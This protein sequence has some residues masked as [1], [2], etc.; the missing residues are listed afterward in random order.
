MGKRK[1][2][3]RWPKDDAAVNGEDVQ[4]AEGQREPRQKIIGAESIQ[5]K[6]NVDQEV[7]N[8]ADSTVAI[9]EVSTA[10]EEPAATDKPDPQREPKPKQETSKE[11]IITPTA[12]SVIRASKLFKASVFTA[13][14]ILAA[15]VGVM[16][17]SSQANKEQTISTV[18]KNSVEYQTLKAA[19]EDRFAE[20]SQYYI[21]GTI[22]NTYQ[23]NTVVAEDGSAYVHGFIAVQE[24]GSEEV[25]P[26]EVLSDY[27]SADGKYYITKIDEKGANTGW[28]D[29]SVLTQN[30]DYIKSMYIQKY[31]ENATSVRRFAQVNLDKNL[32]GVDVYEVGVPGDLFTEALNLM[33]NAQYTYLYEE[34]IKRGDSEFKDMATSARREIRTT[35]QM[36]DGTIELGV[37]DGKLYYFGINTGGGG[38]HYI[39][40]YT[41]KDQIPAKPEV[42]DVSDAVDIYTDAKA[43]FDESQKLMQ[44]YMEEMSQE[45]EDEATTK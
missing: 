40:S 8:T 45:A 36:S 19:V 1:K 26:V 21:D 12:L 42:P 7:S 11:Y 22:N 23:T 9:G 37:K 43:Q 31:L 14:V 24:E 29:A 20:G 15:V 27:I 18:D 10:D 44:Q 5:D 4:A 39:A 3:A 16:I 17:G 25:V 33:Q 32:Q 6:E 38:H 41:I 35:G 34:A 28:V 30:A 2:N 13:A